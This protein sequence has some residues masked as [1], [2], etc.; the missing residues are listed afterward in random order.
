M[1]SRNSE[2]G[3]TL[4]EVLVAMLVFTVGIVALAQLMAVSVYM[5]AH[6]RNQTSAVRLAQDKFDELMSQFNENDDVP[7]VQITG[8]DSLSANTENYFDTVDG[9]TRRWL[10]EAGPDDGHD[11]SDDLRLIT[12]RVIPDV[13]DRRT[14]APYELISI[15][16]RW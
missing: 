5:Q 11:L 6:G 8:E 10:V 2:R 14:F 1:K 7:A 16:R 12:I 15:I 3:F 4:V 9:Y 13:Q